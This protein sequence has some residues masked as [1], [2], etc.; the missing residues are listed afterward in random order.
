MRIIENNPPTPP[1]AESQ[2]PSSDD[3]GGAVAGDV[4]NGIVV[5]DSGQFDWSQDSDWV[6]E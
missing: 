4:V 2:Q 1:P 5:E 3:D 6:W